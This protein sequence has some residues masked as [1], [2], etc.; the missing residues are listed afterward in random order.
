MALMF[1]AFWGVV[2][3]LVIY[4]MRRGHVQ[5]DTERIQTGHHDAERILAERLA[6]G[7]I[8]EEEYAKRRSALRRTE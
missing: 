1:L 5:N 4:L 7:E 3:S 6:R 2:A 8:D